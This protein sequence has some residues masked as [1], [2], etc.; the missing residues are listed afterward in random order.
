MVVV[1]MVVIMAAMMMLV[2]V[3]PSSPL[4][5]A[6][7]N[8]PLGARRGTERIRKAADNGRRADRCN[9]PRM[10]LQRDGTETL[11][12]A[13]DKQ[14]GTVLEGAPALLLLRRDEGCHDAGSRA[15]EGLLSAWIVAG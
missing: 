4:M 12:G 14:K 1:A 15:A 5:K 3:E 13:K 9:L 10:A 6:P 8:P 2:T 7:G 11:N